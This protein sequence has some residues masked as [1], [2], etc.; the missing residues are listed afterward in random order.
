MLD[1]FS[2][3]IRRN[4]FPLYDRVRSMAPLLHEPR[5]R[6]WMVFDYEGVKRVITGHET[7]SS[8]LGPADWIVFRDPPRHTK[9]RALISK[10]FTPRSVVNLE[11]RIGVLA[12]ELLDKTIDRGEMDFA[13][14][15]AVPLPM[16]VIAEMLGIPT[17]DRPRFIRWNDVILNMSYTIPGVSGGEQAKA[18]FTA[19]TAEMSDYL[20]V[21]LEQHRRDPT[22]DLLTRLLQAE[23]EGERLTHHDILGFFQALLLAGSETTT[24]LLNSAILCFIEHPDQLARLRR[25]PELLPSAIEEVLRFRSPVQWMFRYTLCDAP[26]HGQTVPASSVILAMIGSANRDPKVFA[27]SNRFDLAREPNPHIAF[28]HGV[29]FCI[30]APLAQDGSADCADRVSLARRDV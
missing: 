21:I 13:T 8:R 2:D 29:H 12:R 24:N 25:Q 15:F 4:P 20:A 14:E 30:G 26:L 16:M 1:L 23:I 3:D 17:A 10:A 18:E 6:L 22:D 11:P 7:F 27:D 5:S 19:I 9:L 28:G